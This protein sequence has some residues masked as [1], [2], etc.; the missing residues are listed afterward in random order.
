MIT[1]GDMIDALI[2]VEDG[3]VAHGDR[4]IA[5]GDVVDELA[6][7]A[8]VAATADLRVVHAARLIRLERVDFEELVDD[9][10]GLAA[11]VCRALGERARRAEDGAYRSPLASR[12]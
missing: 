1:G 6:C 8:P 10:P 5:R 12:G 2:V 11:A 4:R 7:V 9:V 3:E